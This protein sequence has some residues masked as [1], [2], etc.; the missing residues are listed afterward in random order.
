[1]R[2]VWAR[3]IIAC[4]AVGLALGGTLTVQAHPSA[5]K[6][7]ITVAYQQFGPPPYHDQIW[8][9]AVQKQVAA[10]YPN[11]TV[12]L[13]PIVASEGDYYTK[14]DLMMRS[15][16][17]APDIVREDS[18]LI[19]SDATAGYLAPLDSY[20]KGWSEYSQW[21]PK[22]QSIT[23][24]NGHNYG[25]MNGTD[26]RL[27]WYNKVLFKKAGLPTNWQP[28]SWNDILSA[29]RT[30]KAKLPGVTP[31]NLYS[32]IPMDEASTMQGFEMLLYGTGNPLYDYG[33]KKWIVSSPGFLHALEFVQTVYNPKNL[34]GPTNDIALS[35]SA[36]TVVSNQLLP[37]NK[38]AI[39][40]DG[41]WLPGTWY[42]NGSHPWPQW[43]TVL[44]QA[45]MPTEN[46]QAPHY[47][48][49]S[50]GWAYSISSRSQHKAQ[51]WQVLQMANS[52]ANLA[53]YDVAVANITPRKDVVKVPSYHNVPLNPFF[54]KLLSF[55][56]F[57]PAFPVYPQISNQVDLAMEQVMSGSETPAQA[58]AAYANAVTGIAGASHVEKK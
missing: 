16:S 2:N 56:Q 43:K 58:M 49:L 33:T 6:V 27:V 26:D 31:M 39:D 57:R 23:Q 53:S 48:T 42:K 46:G 52:R 18:F 24:F 1:M 55:T 20:I 8:W 19:G 51:A 44:G 54:T 47:V 40:I 35:G 37:S 17:T 41:S 36:G 15:A 22:M 32:G 29:A 28:K 38:L 34:L 7:T 12:K 14:V 11:I 25:I 10:K 30:I 5:A 45:K 50:G 9:Q 21:Y 4:L 13:L 3:V